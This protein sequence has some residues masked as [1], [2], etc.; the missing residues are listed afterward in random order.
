MLMNGMRI[1][2]LAVV[3]AV[4]AVVGTAAAQDSA[5]PEQQE[6]VREIV[7]GIAEDMTSENV[8]RLVDVIREEIEASG[9][10]NLEIYVERMS[11]DE[12][13]L[14]PLGKTVTLEFVVQSTPEPV[15]VTT[16]TQD[17]SVNAQWSMNHHS[18]DPGD[19]E[20][21]TEDYSVDVVGTID[22]DDE[23]DTFLVTCWGSFTGATQ[24]ISEG[25]HVP[26]GLVDEE[27]ESDREE[28]NEATFVEF[29]AS[30]V[31]RP[32]Q[33]R[34]IASRGEDKLALTLV[35]EEDD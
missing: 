5:E 8:E 11:E 23:S 3:L 27:S 35:V 26:R 25:V 24:H 4:T 18:S 17:F 10:G 9:G 21:V 31:F 7:I 14:E 2:A 15:S 16:A 30:A 32:N 29:Q 6:E 22:M 20:Q 28:V 33:T 13:A 19:E 34:V 12:G 1:V